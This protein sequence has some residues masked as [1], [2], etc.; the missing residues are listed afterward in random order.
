[1][2][3]ALRR[4]FTFV[5]MMPNPSLLDTIDGID[6]EMLVTRLNVRISALLDRNHQIGHSYF[7]GLKD[8]SDLHFAWYR[9]VVPLLQEYFY[10]NSER[11]RA[12]L[13]NKF[14]QTIDGDSVNLSA[15][16]D[17][18]D[19][20]QPKFEIV[21]LEGETFLAALKELASDNS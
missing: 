11:L 6:L 19:S 12:I 1:L 20:D 21:E 5:E 8:S 13:G 17:L 9:R 16:S 2:D 18:Y 7:M 15:F 14:V 4:R 3:I 10:N